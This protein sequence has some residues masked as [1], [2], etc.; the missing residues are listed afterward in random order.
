MPEKFTKASNT[1]EALMLPHQQNCPRKATSS[2]GR[3]RK[4]VAAPLLPHH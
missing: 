3:L 1:S 2:P 4:N